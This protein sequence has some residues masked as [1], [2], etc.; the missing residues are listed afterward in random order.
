MKR[1]REKIINYK[2]KDLKRNKSSLK[3]QIS[4]IKTPYYWFKVKKARFSNG[5]YLQIVLKKF[6][7]S[8]FDILIFQGNKDNFDSDS[9]SESE[10]ASPIKRPKIEKGEH[11]MKTINFTQSSPFPYLHSRFFSLIPIALTN[12][13]S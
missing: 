5:K 7:K 2:K 8:K 4:V 12:M 10:R 13:H 11:F 9:S 1:F 3:Y 6:T